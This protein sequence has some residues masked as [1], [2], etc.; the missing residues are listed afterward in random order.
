MF[1]LFKKNVKT[2]ED[3]RVEGMPLTKKVQFEAVP[4]KQVEAA[5]DGDIRAVLGYT[6]VNYY[7]T[8]EKYLLCIFY[9]REDYSE[10][11]IRFEYRVD[12]LPRGKTKLWSV[13]KDLMR[14][15]LRKF[16]QNI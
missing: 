2:E 14:D 1:G 7:A 13:D 8:K 6:P 4:L 12:D 11:F 3:R 16:G 10:I 9:Y 5:L 15:V